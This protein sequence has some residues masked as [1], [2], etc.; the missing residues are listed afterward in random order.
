MIQDSFD[1]AT[2]GENAYLWTGESGI[3]VTLIMVMAVWIFSKKSG[4]MYRAH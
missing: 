2:K 3:L 4:F 1:T